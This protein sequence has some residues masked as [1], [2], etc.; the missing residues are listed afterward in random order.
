[1]TIESHQHV[2]AVSR[3][4]LFNESD[5]SQPGEFVETKT[6]GQVTVASP[7]IMPTSHSGPVRFHMDARPAAQDFRLG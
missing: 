1:M 3:D 4:V 5:H 2:T 7:V 6:V